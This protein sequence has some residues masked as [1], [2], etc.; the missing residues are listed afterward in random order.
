MK[1]VEVLRGVVGNVIKCG[2]DKNIQL[3]LLYYYYYCI[4]ARLACVE[5]VYERIGENLDLR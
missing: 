4:A 2:G 1:V 5:Y 3:V